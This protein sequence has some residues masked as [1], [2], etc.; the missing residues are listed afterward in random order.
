MS[1]R[2]FTVDEF[3]DMTSFSPHIIRQWC[4]IGPKQGGIRAIKT[5]KEWRIPSSAITE[6][7]NRNTYHAA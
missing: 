5:G 2:Y 4:R 7:E 3:A 6:W 1:T